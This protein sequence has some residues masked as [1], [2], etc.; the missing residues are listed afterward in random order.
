MIA[1]FLLEVAYGTRRALRLLLI[2]WVLFPAPGAGAAEGSAE[3]SGNRPAGTDG[4]ETTLARELLGDLSYAAKVA[5][6]DARSI[7]LAPLSIPKLGKISWR[8][9]AVGL[10][11]AG[12]ITGTVFLD[13][14]IRDAMR[15]IPDDTARSVQTA[16]ETALWAGLGCLYIGGAIK[17]DRSWRRTAITGLESY[18]A[19]FGIARGIKVAAARLRPDAGRGPYQWRE[20]GDSFVSDATAPAFSLAATVSHAFQD[21]W[22]ALIPAYGAA[23]GVGVGRMGMDRHWASDILGSAAVGVCTAKGFLKLHESREAAEE[24]A[25]TPVAPQA[26]LGPVFGPGGGRGFGVVVS[27]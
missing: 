14:R 5:Y 15:K 17:G 8:H 21:R 19:S 18:P 9:V 20:G 26:G 3:G 23:V 12:A 10:A 22:W 7:V 1:P 6:L 16:S 2:V 25:K 4:E 24:A 11:A 13:D 27:F